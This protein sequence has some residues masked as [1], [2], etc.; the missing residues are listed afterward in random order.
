[1]KKRDL[2]TLQGTLMSGN[3][4]VALIENGEISKVIEPSLIPLHFLFAEDP[5]LK[6][7]LRQRSLDTS[8]T[9]SRFVLRELD[10][11]KADITQIV[12]SVNAATITDNF[13]SRKMAAKR[14]MSRL[15]F[16]RIILQR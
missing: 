11:D 5:S 4:P 2:S 6:S 1:M 7:W 16:T 12:L 3:T 10:S 13:G 14:P 9:N 8:R 15:D